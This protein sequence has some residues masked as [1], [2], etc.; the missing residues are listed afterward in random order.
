VAYGRGAIAEV[1][2]NPES[3]ARAS[4]AAQRLQR[5]T[6]GPPTE[7]RKVPVRLLERLPCTGPKRW[8]RHDQ[9]WD[10]AAGPPRSCGMAGW[11]AHTLIDPENRHSESNLCRTCSCACRWNNRCQWHNRKFGI[12]PSRE[13]QNPLAQPPDWAHSPTLAGL[14]V[15]SWADKMRSSMASSLGGRRLRSKSNLPDRD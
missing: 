14:P 8:V 3:L 15:G 4:S 12:Q 9:S 11:R 6:A 10:A 2:T 13:C 5:P 7:S 1:G